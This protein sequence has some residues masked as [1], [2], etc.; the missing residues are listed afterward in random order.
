MHI[1]TTAQA[2]RSQV[3]D[4]LHKH[5][6]GVPSPW[7]QA[8]AS[9]HRFGRATPYCAQLAGRSYAKGAHPWTRANSLVGAVHSDGVGSWA[10]PR[11]EGLF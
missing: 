3:P 8:V 10:P 6:S 7:L 4:L 9:P 11:G 2:V 5:Q 1:S